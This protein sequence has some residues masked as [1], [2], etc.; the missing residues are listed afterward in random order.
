MLFRSHVKVGH[1][2]A[3]GA[4]LTDLERDVPE[5]ISAVVEM[6]RL[7][8]DFDLRGLARRLDDVD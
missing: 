7:L 2:R 8:D 4:L 3:I 1:V 5:S 6:R